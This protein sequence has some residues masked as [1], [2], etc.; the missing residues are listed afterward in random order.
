MRPSDRVQ[1]RAHPKVEDSHLPAASVRRSDLGWTL[2][3]DIAM[4]V[5]AVT[6]VMMIFALGVIR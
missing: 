3:A 5:A 4:S 1:A 2:A 6:G